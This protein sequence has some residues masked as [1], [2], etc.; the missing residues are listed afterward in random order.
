[1]F[2]SLSRKISILPRV[3]LILLCCG[4]T[5]AQISHVETSSSS[6]VSG[7]ISGTPSDSVPTFE[8]GFLT[9]QLSMQPLLRYNW[10]E[11]TDGT[12]HSDSDLCLIKE[13]HSSQKFAPQLEWNGAYTVSLLIDHNLEGQRLQN[14]S[15]EPLPRPEQWGILAK[16]QYLAEG[17]HYQAYQLYLSDQNGQLHTYTGSSAKGE[18]DVCVGQMLKFLKFAAF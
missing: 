1:M 5:L 17:E 3:I 11:A 16:Y 4:N 12:W 9:S 14:V 10:L 13:F 7:T 8:T 6:A 18:T 2:G 15:A